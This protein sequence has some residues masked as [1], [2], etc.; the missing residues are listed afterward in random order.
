MSAQVSAPG[1]ARRGLV[2]TGAVDEGFASVLISAAAVLFAT[3]TARRR[4][5]AERPVP[6]SH[7]RRSGYLEAAAMCREMYRL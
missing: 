7:P 2:R 4:R 6:R 5:Y 1:Y 3:I